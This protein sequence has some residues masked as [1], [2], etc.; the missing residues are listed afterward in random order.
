[1]TWPRASAGPSRW[2][3]SPRVPRA[4]RGR[5]GPDH[6]PGRKP[7]RS[8]RPG[9]LRPADGL[10]TAYSGHN[11]FWLWGPPPATGT[12]AI[13]VNVDPALLRREFSHVR[14]VATFS[15]GLGIDDDEQGAPVY[16]ATG[17]RSSWAAAWPAFRDYS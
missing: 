14:Q 4:A 2:R 16:L 9:P 3:W 5:A 13:A 11:N 15:N 7:R 6:D 8:R 12:D 1:M 17:L 10:P